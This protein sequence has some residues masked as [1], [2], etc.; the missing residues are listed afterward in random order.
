M[1][2]KRHAGRELTRQVTHVGLQGRRLSPISQHRIREQGRP[3][4]NLLAAEILCW[5]ECSARITP[6]LLALDMHEHSYHMDYASQ[7]PRPLLRSHRHA[8]RAVVG[9][10][11]ALR[12]L[13]RTSTRAPNPGSV[14]CRGDSTRRCARGKAA[15]DAIARR[16]RV[17]IDAARQPGFDI[18]R[19]REAQGEA[20][21]TH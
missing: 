10:A 9:R 15:A 17:I 6:P 18:D 13:Q 7:P 16:E 4:S 3:P 21:E 19:L 14:R 20:A 1:R 2:K 12:R 8:P 11:L 5:I